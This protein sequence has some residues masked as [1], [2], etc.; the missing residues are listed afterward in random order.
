MKKVRGKESWKKWEEEREVGKIS[1]DEV[2]KAL[3]RMRNGKA[4]GSDDI[5]V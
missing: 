4:V 3:K 1:K 2:R 5:P